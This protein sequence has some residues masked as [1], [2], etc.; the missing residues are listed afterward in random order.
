M[1]QRGKKKDQGKQRTEEKRKKKLTAD[2]N[3]HS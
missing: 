1:I 2:T 3:L